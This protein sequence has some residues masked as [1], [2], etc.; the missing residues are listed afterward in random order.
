MLLKLQQNL[1]K[2]SGENNARYIGYCLNV[3]S[4]EKTLRGKTYK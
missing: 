3:N 2:K 4:D 1:M